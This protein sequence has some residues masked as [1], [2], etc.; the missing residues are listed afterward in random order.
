[1]KVFTQEQVIKKIELFCDS[2]KSYA[3][4]ARA[5]PCTEGQLCQSRQ[6]Q[7]PAPP[8]IL[9]AIG[10]ERITVYASDIEEKYRD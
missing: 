10:L 5:I 7:I 3:E 9:D 4:A 1:M 6:G 2:Y 8:S